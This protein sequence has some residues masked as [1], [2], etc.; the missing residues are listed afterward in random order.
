METEPKL[1]NSRATT[2]TPEGCV[3]ISKSNHEQQNKLKEIPESLLLKGPAGVGLLKT[4][5]SYDLKVIIDHL[6]DNK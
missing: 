2:S 4:A 5:T 6:L 3:I 1:E